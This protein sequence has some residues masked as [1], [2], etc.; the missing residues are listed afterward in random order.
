MLEFEL[1]GIPTAYITAAGRVPMIERDGDGFRLSHATGNYLVEGWEDSGPQPDKVHRR[2]IHFGVHRRMRLSDV[3]E[4]DRV[5][6]RG[7]DLRWEYPRMDLEAGIG[8]RGGGAWSSALDGV[9]GY[10]NIELRAHAAP[11]E[12]DRVD[13]CVEEALP[14]V[15]SILTGGKV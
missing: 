10:R 13:E 11:M 3:K 6:Y 15:V 2:L 8:P 5:R 9:A 14:Q 7:K 12:G 4:G 1:R